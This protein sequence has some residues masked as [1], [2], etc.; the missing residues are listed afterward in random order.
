LIG[1][2]RNSNEHKKVEIVVK[3]Y[4]EKSVDL[5]ETEKIL[6]GGADEAST[7]KSYPNKSQSDDW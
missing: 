6:K 7:S 3:A 1:F 4:R 2:A 5:K